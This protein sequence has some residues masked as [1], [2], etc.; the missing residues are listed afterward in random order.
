MASS[1][2][3]GLISDAYMPPDYQHRPMT[4]V[5]SKERSHDGLR[6][7]L[8]AGRTLVMFRDTIAGKEEFAGPFFY[9]CISVGKPCYENEKKRFIEIANNSDIPFNLVNGNHSPRSVTLKTNTATRIAINKTTVSPLVYEAGN[10][11]TGENKKLRV[12]IR[13]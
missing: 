12:E 1:D 6:E 7:A 3:H 13:F 2:M 11:L 4:L 5:F 8:F 10:I 9:Q